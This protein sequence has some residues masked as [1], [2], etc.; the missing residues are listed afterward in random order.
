MIKI[1]RYGPDKK[2]L[3]DNFVKNSKNGVFFFLRDYMEYHADR[4]ED[5][6]LIFFKDDELVALMPANAEGDTLFSHAGL[7]FGGIITNQKMNNDLMLD[8]FDSL[9]EYLK[10]NGLKEGLTCTSVKKRKP[11]SFC[12]ANV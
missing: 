9:K 1:K 6:S 3:W 5:H 10:E 11:V 4:F 12:R 2:E 7:T 8:I